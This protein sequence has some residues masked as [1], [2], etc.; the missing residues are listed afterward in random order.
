MLE[1]VLPPAD[2]TT[3]RITIGDQKLEIDIIDVEAMTNDAWAE[4]DRLGIEDTKKVLSVWAELFDKAHGVK[5]THYQVNLIWNAATNM[6]EAIKKKYFQ[7]S[8]QPNTT[9]TSESL[10]P[11]EN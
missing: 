10:E 9:E 7:K 2:E 8:E 1:L 3:I 6:K 11:V 5:L 4:L